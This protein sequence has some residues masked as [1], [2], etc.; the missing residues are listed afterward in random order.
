MTLTRC[1]S[2]LW[3]PE[4]YV[5]LELSSGLHITVAY[6][7]DA[8]QRPRNKRV[9]PLLCN[10]RIDKRSFL[11]NGSLNTPTKIEELLK[12]V[13]SV[14]SAPMLCSEDHR[15]AEEKIESEL[16]VECLA[17]KKRISW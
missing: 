6:R 3:Y 16:R 7:P 2:L 8:G 1:S 15:P 10:R 9:R 13:F 4:I 11:V 14:S 5:I 17:V 12:S